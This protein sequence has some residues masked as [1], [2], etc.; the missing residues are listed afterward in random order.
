MAPRPRFSQRSDN[1][2]EKA[3][4]RHVPGLF[5][6]CGKATQGTRCFAS[7]RLALERCDLFAQKRHDYIG[8]ASRTN[9]V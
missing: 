9:L 4:E 8:S 5:S 2:V 1:Y 3:A 7:V 6:R